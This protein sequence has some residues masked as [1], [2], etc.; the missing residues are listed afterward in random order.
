[1]MKNRHSK[2]GGSLAE[3]AIVMLVMLLFLFGIID[4][5]RAL[6]T[7]TWLTDIAQQATRWAIVRGANCTILDHCGANSNNTYVSQYIVGQDVG[8]VNPSLL[9]IAGD[10]GNGNCQGCLVVVYITYPFTFLPF[11]L[12]NTTINFRVAARLHIDN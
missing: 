4:F 9:G 1:M 10:Y 6:Y 5:G 2:R 7:Y 11:V 3:S 12:P 8:L